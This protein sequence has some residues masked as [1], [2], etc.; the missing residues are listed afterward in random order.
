MAKF[1]ILHYSIL[2]HV[3]VLLSR[4]SLVLNKNSKNIFLCEINENNIFIV[5]GFAAN[6][7]VGV[8]ANKMKRQLMKQTC[9]LGHVHVT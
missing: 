4:F 3:L 6:M 1:M 8:A 5:Q 7:F 9:V 2:K